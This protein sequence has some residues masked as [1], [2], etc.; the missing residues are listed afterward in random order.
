MSI[1][2]LGETLDLHGG[3]LDL[4][5]PHH[6]NEI[7]Q[8]E[9]ATGKLFS[10]CWMHNG[11]VQVNAKKMGKSLGNFFVAREL[12]G[13]VE[14]EAMRYAMMTMH[15]RGPLNFEWVVEDDVYHFPL[16]EDA[17]RRVEYLYKTRERL[18]EIPQARIVDQGG[19][20]PAEISQLDAEMTKALD[21]DLNM[22]V[23]LSKIGEM[24]KAVNEVCDKAGQKKGKA[25]KAVVSAANEAFAAIGKRM[26][27]GN[28][29]SAE[30]LGRI[31][32]RRAKAKGIEPAMVEAMIVQ[33]KE[34]RDAKDFA[35]ADEVRDEMLRMGVAIKDSPD[36]TTWTMS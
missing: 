19:D 15:Y 24:L 18:A 21:D 14:P 35:K 12:F 17:E 16:F 30:I 8:S 10:T 33:R 26:G 11:F 4:V 6:E 27:L 34:A 13:L 7:A 29:A 3:G 2:H 36:G 22:S 1:A 23:A 25:S 32:D 31:R 5:F 9:A 28:Q 20:V